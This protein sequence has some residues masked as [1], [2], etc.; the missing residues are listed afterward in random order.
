[1]RNILLIQFETKV[2][3]VVILIAIIIFLVTV[4]KGVDNFNKSMKRV[5]PG[6][7]EFHEEIR[8]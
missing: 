4:F 3:I 1:M 6:E 7:S 5:S 8:F 2:A